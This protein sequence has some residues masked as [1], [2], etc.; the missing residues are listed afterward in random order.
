MSKANLATS[1]LLTVASYFGVCAVHAQTLTVLQS[2]ADFF[3]QASVVSTENFDGY[4]AN[5]LLK[6]WSV[7]FDDV[8]YAVANG[9]TNDCTVVSGDV[10]W[11]IR[12]NPS[13]GPE[14]QSLPNLLFSNGLDVIGGQNGWDVISF[15][16]NRAVD[17]FGFYFI[18]VVSYAHI[19]AHELPD[20]YG[21]DLVVQECNGTNTQMTLGPETAMD[22]S[23]FGFVSTVGICQIELGVK[24]PPTNIGFSG[25][26]W[27]YDTVSRSAIYSLA[28][29]AALSIRPRRVNPDSRG[30]IRVD[31][32]SNED[33]DPLQ[34]DIG[35]IRF[36][37]GDARVSR[38]RVRDVNRDGVADLRLRFQ[39]RSAEISC[40]DNEVQLRGETYAGQPVIADGSVRTI[41]CKRR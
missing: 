8:T 28:I 5:T 30:F 26:N 12:D 23:F 40:G 13:D 18:S 32:L 35:S 27:A 15:G 29:E 20:F 41:R 39:M 11:I 3:S 2:E 37:P 31:L 25:S 19:V 36:G 38:Y 7:V 16:E 1:M 24:G 34:V 21:W 22:A 9:E 17:A 10:C 6:P 4:P 14:P 33:F